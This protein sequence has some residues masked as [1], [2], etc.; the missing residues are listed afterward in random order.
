MLIILS[1][2]FR[3]IDCNFQA[4][5]SFPFNIESVIKISYVLPMKLKT[6]IADGLKPIK[7]GIRSLL[8]GTAKTT[9]VQI[10]RSV[11]TSQISFQIDLLLYYILINL[12]SIY[13]MLSKIIAAAV[14]FLLNFIARKI[15]LFSVAE[16]YSQN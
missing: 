7:K 10:F 12:F 5:N 9:A 6:S 8:N 14:V 1:D 11:S 15:F 13:Y 2:R 3:I 16:K 4:G